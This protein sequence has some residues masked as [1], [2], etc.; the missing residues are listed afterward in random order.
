MIIWQGYGPLTVVFAILGIVFGAFISPSEPGAWQGTV[1]LLLAA[2][3]NYFTAKKLAKRTRTLIDPETGQEVIL[4][5]SHSL[6]FIPMLYWS[7]II[8]ALAVAP[9]FIPID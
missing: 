4:K 5:F 8:A 1:G 7:Y 6:F 9:L 3:A 2:A